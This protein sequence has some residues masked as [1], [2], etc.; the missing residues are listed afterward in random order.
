MASYAMVSACLAVEGM[1]IA[2]GS[3]NFLPDSCFL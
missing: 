3:I 2:W 1:I